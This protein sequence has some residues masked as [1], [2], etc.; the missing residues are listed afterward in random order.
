[1][2]MPIDFESHI[3]ILYTENLKMFLQEKEKKKRQTTLNF[4]VFLR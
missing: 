4:K 2:L 1:M 3:L